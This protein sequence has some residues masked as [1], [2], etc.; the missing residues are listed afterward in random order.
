MRFKKTFVWFS[1]LAILAAGTA[2]FGISIAQGSLDSSPKTIQPT[3]PVLGVPLQQA[4]YLQDEANTIAIVRAYGDS[5]VYVTSK[6]NAK[7]VQNPTP[8]GVPPQFAP[9]FG[10]GPQ[11]IPSQEDIGS[12]FVISTKGYVVTNYHVVRGANEIT[13]KF[14]NDPTNYKA[15]VLGAVEPL[16]LALLKVDVPAGKLRPIP[17]GD[18]SQILVGEKVLAIGNPFGLE[19]TVTQGIVS[20][21]RLNTGAESALIPRVIQT[22]AAINPGNSGGP[23]INSHGQVIGVNSSIFS[24]SGSLGRQAAQFAGVGFAIPINLVKTYLTQMEAGKKVTTQEILTRPPYLGVAVS[25]LTAYP[26]AIRARFHLP[27]YGLMVEHV[28]KGSLAAKAGLRAATASKSVY[29]QDS[30][31]NVTTLGVNGDILLEANGVKLT[32]VNDLRT[33]LFS[34]KKSQKII[35]KVKRDGRIRKVT[36]VSNP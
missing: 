26:K 16:D 11:Q 3:S 22:D 14:Q 35:L 24:P 1:I 27:D 19:S 2:I 32:T 34:A 6:T 30:R 9:F 28:Y 36:I 33:A 5:V 4:G 17:L 20:A 31:G 21:V 25:E 29:L 7:V 18:S 13:V 12:G 15:R 10:F 23:L 8:Q